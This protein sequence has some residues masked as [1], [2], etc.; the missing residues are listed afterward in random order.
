MCSSLP[1]AL[2]INPGLSFG[3]GSETTLGS[4]M[5]GGKGDLPSALTRIDPGLLI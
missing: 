2:D 3:R 4:G 1:L 5:T